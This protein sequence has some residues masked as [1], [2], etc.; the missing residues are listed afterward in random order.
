VRGVVWPGFRIPRISS[1]DAKNEALLMANA[2]ATPRVA[3]RI[4]P[5]T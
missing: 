4:P 1:A 3:K 5:Q 2:Q